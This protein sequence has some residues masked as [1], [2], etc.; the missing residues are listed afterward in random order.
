MATKRGQL[1]AG[2]T[3]IRP[4]LISEL[5]AGHAP[6]TFHDLLEKSVKVVVRPLISGSFKI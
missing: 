5:D 4:P 2:Y 3:T 6:P 1:L